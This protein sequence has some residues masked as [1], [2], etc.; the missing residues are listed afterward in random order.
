[1]FWRS[2]YA[3]FSPTNASRLL[4]ASSTIDVMFCI[5]IIISS[6]SS[7]CSIV[8]STLGFWWKVAIVSREGRGE[9]E[10][11]RADHT[12]NYKIILGLKVKHGLLAFSFQL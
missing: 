8:Y 1:M 6:N 12:D 11:T 9:N 5:I 2:H 7:S 10:K 3:H 4:R